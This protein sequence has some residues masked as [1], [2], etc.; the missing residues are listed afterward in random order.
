VWWFL[1]MEFGKVG[2]KVRKLRWQKST[3]LLPTAAKLSSWLWCLQFVGASARLAMRCMYISRFSPLTSTFNIRVRVQNL[4]FVRTTSKSRQSCQGPNCHTPP[5]CVASKSSVSAPNQ[6]IKF[7]IR[8]KIFSPNSK[9][10]T[11]FNHQVS[12]NKIIQISL[13]WKMLF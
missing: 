2:G 11:C 10:S 4:D 1:Q 7:V 13:K 6:I 9:T 8:E 5:V 3:F 12:S